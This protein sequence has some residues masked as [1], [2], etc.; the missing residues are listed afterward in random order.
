MAMNHIRYGTG[1]PLLLIH[2]LGSNWRTWRPVL[3]A[4]AAAREVVAI[5]LPGFGKT[6]P[7]SGPVTISALA[8]SVTGFLHDNGLTGVDAVGSS[9]G[10]RLVLEL[11]RRGD[12]IGSAVA[13]NPGGF[14]QGWERHF[15]Y[16]SIAVSVRLVRLLQPLMPGI[17]HSAVGR[18][19]LFP[20]FSPRPW[21]LSP[22][23][24]L[25]EMRS[26]AASPSFNELLYNLAYGEEQE[27]APLHSILH[28]LTIVWGRNDRVCFPAQAH[29]ALL[30]FPDARLQWLTHCG[31]FPHWDKP[32]ETAHVILQATK[33][34][35]TGHSKPLVM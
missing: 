33:D 27:G 17:T 24:M 9:M 8:D 2:G 29:R 1:K 20:Q 21:H 10:A 13:L 4:L 18:T 15:F 31:H 14:W 30:K 26:Y 35:I 34:P 12:I 28:P 11:A 3:P 6:P 5:D 25:D 23:V 19:L 7:L 16:G 32:H 22:D